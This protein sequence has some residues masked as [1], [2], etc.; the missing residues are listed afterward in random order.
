MSETLS[1]CATCGVEHA[2]PLPD[3]CAICADERQ[4]LPADGKQRWTTLETLRLDRTIEVWEMEPNL[5]GIT[6]TPP[7]GIGHRPILVQTPDGN[8]LWDPPAFI[9]E[10]AVVRIRELGEVRW[11]AA[12]HPH[13][14]GVQLEWSHAFGGIPVLV[15]G[16][17]Q[18]WLA[19]TGTAIEHWD[20]ERELA[21][22]LRLIRVG[23]HFPGSAVVHLSGAD[24]AGVL[25][26]SDSIFPVAAAG[27]VTFLR[28]YPNQ[29]PL[30][31]NAVR[32]IVERIDGLDFDR[33][34]GNFRE[35]ACLGGAK[36]SVRRSADRYIGWVS[37]DFDDEN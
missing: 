23:G 11:I 21:P 22:G 12:S 3:R 15:N 29:I 4:Y 16:R 10:A 30:S 31:A 25:L 34:Y 5:W 33:L 36:E 37:G 26:S 24:H 7:V 14:F 19:R 13:M 27:W 2:H 18:A 8:L 1:L 9:D 35:R 20:E 6:T 28:S 17:D 32:R